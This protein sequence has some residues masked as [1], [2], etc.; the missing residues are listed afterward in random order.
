M[1]EAP[2]QRRKRRFN[3]FNPQSREEMAAFLA[4]VAEAVANDEIVPAN[5]RAAKDS[6][7]LIFKLYIDGPLKL[8]EMELR[9]KGNLPV[10]SALLEQMRA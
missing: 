4:D 8:A 6:V 5:V 2:A 10:K 1:L 3:S 7:R 9:F